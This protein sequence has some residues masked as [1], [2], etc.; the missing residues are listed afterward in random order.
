MIFLL[1]LKPNG[2][3]K[4]NKNNFQEQMIMDN[5]KSDDNLLGN[6]KTCENN[7]ILDYFSL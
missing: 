5:I 3:L 2:K 6:K 7:P 1:I 4:Q